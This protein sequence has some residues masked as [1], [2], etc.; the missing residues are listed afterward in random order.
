MAGRVFKMKGTPM[1]PIRSLHMP[2]A[3]LGGALVALGYL[4]ASTTGG[5]PAYAQTVLSGQLSFY[6]SGRPAILTASAD[7][8]TLYFWSTTVNPEIL[9]PLT[10][11]K[12]VGKTEAQQ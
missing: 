8:K 7:G 3:L 11:P 4:L 9:N 2:S 5:N 12:L 10:A 1:I 6:N